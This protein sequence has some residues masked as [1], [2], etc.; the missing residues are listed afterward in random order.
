[1]NM[2][3]GKNSKNGKELHK[4]SDIDKLFQGLK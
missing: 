2:Q 1:M 3:F 4:I